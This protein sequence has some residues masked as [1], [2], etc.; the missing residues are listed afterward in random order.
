M[1]NKNQIK[2]PFVLPKKHFLFAEP[3]FRTPE[4]KTH[5]E[6]PVQI[7][8]YNAESSCYVQPTHL[9]RRGEFQNRFLTHLTNLH[10]QS[11]IYRFSQFK[12][13]NGSRSALIKDQTNRLFL[14]HGTPELF[15]N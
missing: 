7:V 6:I 11:H 15:I 14:G 5:I 12:R 4:C 10:S 9:T 3:S 1:I 8:R 2:V 13:V